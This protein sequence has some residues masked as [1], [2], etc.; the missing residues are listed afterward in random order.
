M[1]GQ[2]GER[3]AHVGF[4][5]QPLALGADKD[6]EFGHQRFSAFLPGGAATR[7]G[8]SATD[9]RFDRVE[10]CNALQDLVT[11]G[12]AGLRDRLDHFA[13][14]VAPAIGKPERRTTLAIRLFKPIIAGVWTDP[15]R[16]GRFVGGEARLSR[17]L[18]PLRRPPRPSYVP[19]ATSRSPFETA[20]G[21]C[22]DE[23]ITR[24]LHKLVVASIGIAAAKPIDFLR[25]FEERLRGAIHQSRTSDSDPAKH[26]KQFQVLSLQVEC[27]S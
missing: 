18:A 5:R 13:P 17:N 19:T 9:L 7:L 15:K 23:R 26:L 4:A 3:L 25:S 8:R 2:I 24:G 10:R 27:L 16:I 11:D 22:S 1:V 21:K 20:S 6:I 14:G 12:R